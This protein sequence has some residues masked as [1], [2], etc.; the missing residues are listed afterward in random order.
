MLSHPRQAGAHSLEIR[1]ESL[2]YVGNFLLK[3]LERF[4]DKRPILERYLCGDVELHHHG[5]AT[6][7]KS[8]AVVAVPDN[9]QQ[10]GM[11]VD[12]G[13]KPDPLRPLA[14]LE[15]LQPLERCLVS[16]R[17]RVQPALFAPLGGHSV[18]GICLVPTLFRVFN[19]KLR[20]ILDLT[21]I[22]DGELV[23]EEIERSSEVVDCLPDE[24]GNEWWGFDSLLSAGEKSAS[25]HETDC[26]LRRQD[27]SY[28]TFKRVDVFACPSYSRSR[29]IKG[30]L[31]AINHD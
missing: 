30:W 6:C 9:C 10:P 21:R 14:T 28:F 25:G 13:V 8:R 19:Q 2:N 5:A 20:S 15:R 24:D 23:D 22:K 27:G 26:S 31:N 12:V 11:L 7:V 29:I 17:E 4:H 1:I 3:E 16:G 18:A